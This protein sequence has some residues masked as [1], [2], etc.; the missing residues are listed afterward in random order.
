M[1]GFP[2]TFAGSPNSIQNV[3]SNGDQLAST[4]DA[5]RNR[6]VTAPPIFRKQYNADVSGSVAFLV[7][8]MSAA[9]G[10]QEYGKF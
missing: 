3:L 10:E 2:L 7:R 5:R 1:A 9:E 8:C 4:D 6:W